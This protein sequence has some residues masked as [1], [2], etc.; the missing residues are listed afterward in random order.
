MFRIYSKDTSLVSEY[1]VVLGIIIPKD[2]KNCDQKNNIPN[3]KWTYELTGEDFSVATLS[4][5]HQT[6]TCLN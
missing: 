6:V 1:L 4:Y 2:N 3:F 5:S